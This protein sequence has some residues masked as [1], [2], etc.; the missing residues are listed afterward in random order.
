MKYW[1]DAAG[2]VTDG[3]HV[4][5]QGLRAGAATDL[6]ENGATDEELERAGRWRP[7]SRI[8]RTVYVRPAQAERKDPF[9]R[10][11]VHTPEA[12]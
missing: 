2:L 8:P 3:R 12:A 4:S 10:V 7:G 1:F 6:A 5:S 11:P 9:V